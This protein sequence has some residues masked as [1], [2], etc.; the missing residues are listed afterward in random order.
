M[1]INILCSKRNLYLTVT[2]EPKV[3]RYMYNDYYLIPSGFDNGQK[4]KEHTG[5]W[6]EQQ[7]PDEESGT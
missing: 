5:Y 4:G 1:I 3:H 6:T 7:E 2:E